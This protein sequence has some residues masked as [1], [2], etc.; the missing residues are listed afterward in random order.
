[1]A[2]DSTFLAWRKKKSLLLKTAFVLILA[3]FVLGYT[4][5]VSGSV[6]LIAAAFILWGAAGAASFLI[7]S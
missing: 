6:P 5:G 7:K 4:G 2:D 1:M 3:G